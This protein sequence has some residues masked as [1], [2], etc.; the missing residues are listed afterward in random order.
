MVRQPAS[1]HRLAWSALL[2]V[3]AFGPARPARARRADPAAAEEARERR[4]MERF[5]SLLE[6]NPRRGTALDRVYGYHVERGT[7]DDLIKSYRD[8]LAKD[9]D[10]GDGRAD[11]RPAGVPA[12][13]G[14]RGRRRA[15]QGRDRAAR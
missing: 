11:P 12:R 8:R 14:R 1:L 6:K 10:D 5:L 4:A 13:A 9:A 3:L 7:L 15:P 2:L